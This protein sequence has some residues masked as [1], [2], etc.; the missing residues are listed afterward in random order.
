M[1]LI[2]RLLL[3]TLLIGV[4]STTHPATA[5]GKKR[6]VVK[7]RSGGPEVIIL[8]SGKPRIYHQLSATRPS[9]VEVNGPG[10]LRVLTRASLNKQSHGETGY[11]ILYRI[12]HGSRSE[13]DVDGVERA[14]DAAYKE[15]FAGAPGE[16][17]E[18]TLTIGRGHHSI[19]FLLRDSLTSVS[20]R[21]LLIPRTQKKITWITMSP[22][23]P[24]EPVDL[25]AGEETLHYYRFSSM[26]PL[27]IEIIGPTELRIRTRLENS[28]TMKGRTN[29]RIQIREEGRVEQSFQLSSGRSEVTL[30][31]TT[32]K[33]V[34]G[35]VREIVFKVPKGKHRYE[36]LSLDDHTILGQVLFPQKDAKLG[37]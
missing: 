3:V 15:G 21:Y 12:D 9:V 14:V 1:T 6:I 17:E 37:L 20:A 25:H 16:V 5:A 11:G 19:E 22:L 33:L 8:V 35:K 18:L 23:A 29:Y 34:P 10:E 7:P 28:F 31:R 4:S 13:F 24:V 26:K 32:P 30:Y 36:I 27:R 2:I